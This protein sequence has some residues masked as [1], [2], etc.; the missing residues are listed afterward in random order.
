MRLSVMYRSLSVLLV[1]FATFGCAVFTDTDIGKKPAPVV[2]CAEG[3]MRCSADAGRIEICACQD[4]ACSFA[5]SSSCESSQRCTQGLNSVECGDACQGGENE[6]FW[7]LDA[8]SDNFSVVDTETLSCNSPGSGYRLSETLQPSIDCNDD[9]AD[10]NPGA[11]ESPG[12]E[13]DENC[14]GQIACFVDADRD[15]FVPVSAGRPVSATTDNA[16]CRQTDGFSLLAGN[17]ADC[18]D[19]NANVNPDADELCNGVDDDCDG[20]PDAGVGKDPDIAGSCLAAGKKGCVDAGECVTDTCFKPA[21]ANELEDEGVCISSQP[22]CQEYCALYDEVKSS[23]DFYLPPTIDDCEPN[24]DLPPSVDACTTACEQSLTD[25]LPSEP[26]TI[27]SYNDDDNTA[28]IGCRSQFFVDAI[29]AEGS[30]ERATACSRGTLSMG[31]Y[32]GTKA[33]LGRCVP[34]P[35][36]N[37]DRGEAY[38]GPRCAFGSNCAIAGTELDGYKV[39]LPQCSFT[40]TGSTAIQV[41][42]C[43]NFPDMDSS[44]IGQCILGTCSLGGLVRDCE[45]EVSIRCAYGCTGPNQ[46]CDGPLDNDLNSAQDPSLECMQW[47]PTGGSP[48]GACFPDEDVIPKLLCTRAISGVFEDNDEAKLVAR[49][50]A[51]VLSDLEDVNSTSDVV[52]ALGVTDCYSDNAERCESPTV[53]GCDDCLFQLRECLDD[54]CENSCSNPEPPLGNGE[55]NLDNGAC[56]CCMKNNTFDGDRTC[57]KN[58]RFC[59]G[60]DENFFDSVINNDPILPTCTGL[61]N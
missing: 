13:V 9:R 21:D 55:D 14:D 36:F 45:G 58:F 23:C 4:D 19:N 37:G 32:C 43:P 12:N 46:S 56:V 29:F 51:G 47:A 1:A 30:L 49:G 11:A 40:A 6:R 26:L 60:L 15:G 3:A 57:M 54:N 20:L 31:G 38:L 8:D 22:S 53:N 35:E 50:A 27:G 18:N 7:A 25:S 2:D 48:D 34:D 41:A 17:A 5:Q 33:N 39:C 59:S 42:T 28:S 61:E 10:V 44:L 16:Q 24:C 52:A